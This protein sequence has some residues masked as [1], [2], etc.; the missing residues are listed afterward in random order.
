M[1]EDFYHLTGRPFRL[2][3]DP[4]FYFD[5]TAH[6]KAMAYLSFGL[7][8][9][10]GFIVITGD[11]GTGKTTVIRH[12]LETLDPDSYLAAVISTTQLDGDSLLR[13]VA[14]A[15]NIQVAAGADKG[16]VLVAVEAFLRH[17]NSEDRR[18]LLIIDEAQNLPFTALEELRMLSNFQDGEHALVQSFLVGQS[19]FRQKIFSSAELEQLRQRVIASHHLEHMGQGDV[20][21][22][23][24]HRLKL[25]GWQ[26]DP[27]F[28]D[29]A[30]D[31][32]HQISGGIP[33]KLNAL[34]NRL[35]LHGSLQEKHHLN[36]EDVD[37]VAEE[38][39][40][41]TGAQAARL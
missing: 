17:Q 30:Y 10:E 37:E 22:Y 34:C 13:V 2:T 26:G 6:K 25:V 9:E 28:T 20:A 7:D 39:L 41:E 3:P 24:E 38:F 8:Q 27:D 21:D 19:Q 33:R 12:L 14:G 18:V 11:V 4:H 35:L 15:L 31:R 23:V 36:V 16:E 40:S 29:G 32:M 1:Y 5:S